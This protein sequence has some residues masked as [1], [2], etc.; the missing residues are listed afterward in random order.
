VIPVRITERVSKGPLTDDRTG[1]LLALRASE[2]LRYL[3]SVL[4][5]GE[6][7]AELCVSVNTVKAHLRSIYRQLGVSRPR[8]A[9]VRAHQHGIL[10]GP[11]PPDLHPDE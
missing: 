2:I 1:W 3:P 6:I 7:G 11:F 5:A 9:V 8:D 10:H 4:T